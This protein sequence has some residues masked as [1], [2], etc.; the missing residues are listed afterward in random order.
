[1]TRVS[2][3]VVSHRV[4]GVKFSPDGSSV[5]IIS[6]SFG[7][8]LELFDIETGARRWKHS[9]RGAAFGKVTFSADG[10]RLTVGGSTNSI[11]ILDAGDGRVMGRINRVWSGSQMWPQAVMSPDGTRVAVAHDRNVWVHATSGHEIFSFRPSA[12]CGYMRYSPD[13]T[14][15]ATLGKDGVQ[16]WDAESAQLQTIL[17]IPPKTHDM[18]FGGC[19]HVLMTVGEDRA[20]RVWDVASS[21][22]PRRIHAAPPGTHTVML[23]DDGRVAVSASIDRTVAVWDM[24]AGYERTRLRNPGPDLCAVSSDGTKLATLGGKKSVEIWRIAVAPDA[25][26]EPPRDGSCAQCG[27][28]K[29]AP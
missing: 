1:M 13:G 17:Q 28:P 26:R 20:V 6:S 3:C 8:T 5:A 4:S 29:P 18:A 7:D 15:I 23:G 11:P 14:R 25:I 10:R 27:A 22:E 9:G 21:V 19:G 24:M 16:V 12:N 2:S